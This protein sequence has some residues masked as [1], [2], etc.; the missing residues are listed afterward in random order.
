MIMMVT[1]LCL[2]FYKSPERGTIF[3][4][5]RHGEAINIMLSEYMV[6]QFYSCP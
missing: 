3:K 4:R 6:S 1:W 5:N 2:A